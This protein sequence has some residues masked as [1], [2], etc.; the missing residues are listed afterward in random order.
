MTL[1]LSTILFLTMTGCSL[2]RPSVEEVRNELAR[3]IDPALDA[4]LGEAER[5]EA[6]IGGGYCHEPLIGPANGIR[7][8]LGYTFSWTVLEGDPNDFLKGVE[9][10]WR[11]EGLEIEV[12]ETDNARILFSGKDGYN[13]S[14]AIIFDSME[15]DIG[16][17]GPCVDHPDRD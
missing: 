2:L 11:S 10:H 5:P 16:G 1:A 15:A 13:L 4:G 14:A 17:Y 3:L 6:S 8:T 12:D 9:D 7:P